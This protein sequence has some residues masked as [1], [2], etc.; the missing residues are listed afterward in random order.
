[1]K[2]EEAWTLW[3]FYIWILFN[4]FLQMKMP[5]RQHTFLCAC[6]CVVNNPLAKSEDGAKHFVFWH[7]SQGGFTR[8]FYLECTK[9]F[10]YS[11][12]VCCSQKPWLMQ[13]FVMLISYCFF[14]YCAKR[15]IKNLIS[16]KECILSIAFHH[17]DSRASHLMFTNKKQTTFASLICITGLDSAHSNYS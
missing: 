2:R 17:K 9:V 6:W 1:M 14:W 12:Q 5:P 15:Q 3:I 16:L 10:T 7:F 13:I 4:F 11:A 8:S